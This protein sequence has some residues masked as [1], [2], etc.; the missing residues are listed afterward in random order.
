MFSFKGYGFETCH[1]SEGY[2][3]RLTIAFRGIKMRV[4]YYTDGAG[5]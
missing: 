2:A 4:N 5:L 3:V 1:Y